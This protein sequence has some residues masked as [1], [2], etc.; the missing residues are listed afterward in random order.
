MQFLFTRL[1]EWKQQIKFPCP[2][3]EKEQEQEARAEVKASE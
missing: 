2:Q 3:Q 1:T